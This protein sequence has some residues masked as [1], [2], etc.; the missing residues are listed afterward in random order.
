M[1]SHA[2][3]A[4]EL[5]GIPLNTAKHD[6][7]VNAVKQAGVGL[8]R[9]GGETRWFDVYDSKAV[10]PGSSILYL[11]YVKQDRRFAFAEYEFIGL[12]Q[13]QIME[14]LSLKYGKPAI[15][16]GK[17]LSDKRYRWQKNGIDIELWADWRHYRSRLSYVNSVALGDLKQEQKNARQEHTKSQQ[18]AY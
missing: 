18:L 16:S 3:S 13:P 11:G 15:V 4:A 6:D 12:K 5:F 7:L 10:L 8:I 17:Y 9:E 14:K 2:A 1:L